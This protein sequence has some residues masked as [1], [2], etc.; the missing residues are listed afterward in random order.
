MTSLAQVEA[1]A[2]AYRATLA[3]GDQ[4][5]V[6][7]T[8]ERKMLHAIVASSAAD[9]SQWIRSRVPS[10]HNMA[11][12]LQD[13]VSVLETG[14]WIGKGLEWAKSQAISQA[15]AAAAWAIL[16]MKIPVLIGS[17]LA[18]IAGLVGWSFDAGVT[19]GR[20]LIPLILGGGGAALWGILQG[21]RALF[22][23]A[24]EVGRAANTLFE[25]AGAIGGEA[26]KLFRGIVN[27]RLNDIAGLPYNNGV[28]VI[29]QVRALA[30]TVVAACYLLAG[31]C[32]LVFISGVWHALE[33]IQST[34]TF[35]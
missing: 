3:E 20:A 8:V 17:T 16:G 29:R 7:S 33:Q 1:L 6:H 13:L 31:L 25:S 27:V 5:F 18:L 15:K 35:P 28:P 10:G 26:E 34:P 11:E 24:N 2:D 14:N 30:S 23:A 12:P 21:A 9:A 32:G 4:R 22:P 19:V